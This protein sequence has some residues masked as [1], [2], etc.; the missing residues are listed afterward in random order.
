MEITVSRNRY[1]KGEIIM[2][3][4]I[5]N[6]KDLS[7]AREIIEQK[8]PRFMLYFFYFILIMILSLLTWSYLAK[9]EIVVKAQGMVVADTKQSITPLVSG[10]I[11]KIYFKEGDIVKEGDLIL[12]MEHSSIYESLKFYQSSRD[13]Y[14]EQI[15]LLIKFEA[16]I[17]EAKNLFDKDKKE[18]LGNYY[19]YQTYITESNLKDTEQ[20]K[21]EFKAQKL[22]EI[23]SQI[24]NLDNYIKQY[25]VEILKLETEIGHYKFYADI[26]GII[27]F[28]NPVSIGNTLQAG[29]EAIRIN[30]NTSKNKLQIIVSNQDIAK[31]KV[32]QAV[33]VDVKAL[34]NR[35]YGF[36]EARVTKIETDTRV[37]Q[38]SG[39]SFYI[40]EAELLTEKLKNND[41]VQ[42]LKVGMVVE[43]RMITRE[44]RYLYWVIEKLGLWIFD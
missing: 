30:S 43:S 40:V 5:I 20:E 18:E 23:Y 36:G 12:E 32:G 16:S 42:E 33:R 14:Q 2:K 22:S 3:G 25:G 44:Q 34:P 7:D 19:E 27:H 29:Y 13:N 24:E 37:D 4:I 17:L 9:K 6:F 39:Q 15:K 38:Q 41:D 8:T 11:S 28:V 1:G 31:I 26:E 21:E 10:Q 35:E